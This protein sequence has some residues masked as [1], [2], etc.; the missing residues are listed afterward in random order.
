MFGACCASVEREQELLVRMH[1][2]EQKLDIHSTPPCDLEPLCDPFDLFYKACK[3][4]YGESFDQ[5]RHHGKQQARAEDEEYIEDDDDED[6]E[7]E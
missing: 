5:P 3:E 4:F 7:D 6:Y 1:R 2:F